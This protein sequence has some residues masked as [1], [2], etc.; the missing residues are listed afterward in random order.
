M[1]K[2]KTS[3]IALIVAFAMI[4]SVACS[5]GNGYPDCGGGA[6]PPCVEEDESGSEERAIK[7]MQSWADSIQS[8]EDVVALGPLTA[9]QK[10]GGGDV[11]T[12]TVKTDGVNLFTQIEDYDIHGNWRIETSAYFHNGIWYKSTSLGHAVTAADIDWSIDAADEIT[13]MT[14]VFPVWIIL[15]D[16]F[17]VQFISAIRLSNGNYTFIFSFDF[18]DEYDSISGIMVFHFDSYGRM[19]ARHV[20]DDENGYVTS[21]VIVYEEPEIDW[22]LGVGDGSNNGNGFELGDFVGNITEE[23]AIQIKENW[24]DKVGTLEDFLNLGPLSVVIE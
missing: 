11:F 23:Q 16:L 1:K 22:P 15:F 17:D 20:I 7:L 2:L 9:I 5:N 13:L 19:L 8:W 4:F 14:L 21:T 12:G 10:S 6:Q 24:L 18:E 3:I